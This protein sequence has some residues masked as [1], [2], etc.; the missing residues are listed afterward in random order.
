MHLA[1]QCEETMADKIDIKKQ[2]KHLFAP[3]REPH[4]AEV[5]KFRY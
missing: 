1:E 2:Y 3:K 4:L 5:P